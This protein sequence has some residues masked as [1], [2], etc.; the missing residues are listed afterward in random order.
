[1]AKSF[2]D[3]VKEAAGALGEKKDDVVV[4]GTSSVTAI[5]V[6]DS[7][8]DEKL[9]GKVIVSTYNGSTGDF[10]YYL[11]SSYKEPDAGDDG[12]TLVGKK[13]EEGK[14]LSEA[15][16]GRYRN[17]GPRILISRDSTYDEEVFKKNARLI[18]NAIDK[19]IENRKQNS[20]K[21]MSTA[22]IK[23]FDGESSETV[24]GAVPYTW[25]VPG[26][27]K[28]PAD[29]KPATGA[30][31]KNNDVE[32]QSP[33]ER[34][35]VLTKIPVENKALPKFTEGEGDIYGYWEIKKKIL[36]AIIEKAEARPYR[37]A[38]KMAKFKV[39]KIEKTNE[40]IENEIRA[41][42][43]WLYPG[44]DASEKER[45]RREKASPKEIAKREREHA[46]LID[47]KIKSRNVRI[48]AV[49]NEDNDRVDFFVYTGAGE[50]SP[51]KVEDF[52]NNREVFKIRKVGLQVLNKRNTPVIELYESKKIGGKM[53]HS[54]ILNFVDMNPAGNPEL[55]AL[56]KAFAGAE[57]A[58]QDE[59]AFENGF[60]NH[61]SP[62]LAN[63]LD[64]Q[65]NKYYENLIEISKDIDTKGMTEKEKKKAEKDHTKAIK[66]ETKRMSSLPSGFKGGFLKTGAIEGLATAGIV[67][68]FGLGGLLGLS[69]AFTQIGG[70][71]GNA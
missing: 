11:A 27:S 33:E 60:F 12:V 48:Y 18:L 45:A 43:N 59:K 23:K 15:I 5:L 52:A 35:D 14:S 50:F 40:R 34:G 31:V 42:D 21:K 16:F 25:G 13:V 17:N 19:S 61:I 54:E 9:R 20:N 41:I 55:L 51:K 70:G 39:D 24:S 49:K 7:Y 37:Q 38:V 32:T 53:V 1:M 47:Q 57:K 22:K 26:E 68:A 10:T 44:A 64:E 65:K 4:V 30:G 69:T 66:A 29:S 28:E 67:L 3:R 36:S 2:Y 58:I 8:E 71:I 6:P 56:C 62:N 46:S 63:D